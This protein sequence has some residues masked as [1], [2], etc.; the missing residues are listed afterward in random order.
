MGPLRARMQ[1]RRLGAPAD[2]FA[3]RARLTI[4]RRRVDLH[5]I[6][7]GA[8]RRRVELAACMARYVLAACS[9]YGHP[10]AER[11]VELHLPR[12]PARRT[13]V[14]VSLVKRYRHLVR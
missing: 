10:L 5:E 6:G 8:V 11:L 13:R 12:R 4:D 9:V 14:A 1:R 2:L 3:R 7:E